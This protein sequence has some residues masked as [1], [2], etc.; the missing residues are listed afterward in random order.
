MLPAG[1]LLFVGGHVL[2]D[3]VTAGNISPYWSILGNAMIGGGTMMM[4]MGMAA[5]P[6]IAAPA[7]A[8]SFF[9]GSIFYGGTSYLSNYA[10]NMTFN[11][12]SSGEASK[13][14]ALSSILPAAIG[15]FKGGLTA[16]A[17]DKNFWWGTKVGNKR[18]QWSFF[19]WD[20]PKH[21]VDF[22]IPY[23][24]DL[25]GKECLAKA[26]Y[27]L[28]QKYGGNRSLNDFKKLLGTTTEGTE[29][30]MDELRDIVTLFEDLGFSNEQISG[31]NLANYE[32]VLQY[33]QQNNAVSFLKRMWRNEYH[34]SNIDKIKFYPDYTKIIPQHGSNF[35]LNDIT[36][37]YMYFLFP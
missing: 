32:T 4:G 6:G 24:G 1:A 37:K 9:G 16:L 36:F 28:E 18:S 15:G 25:D 26:A 13:S 21:V 31:S 30:A 17:N 29:L 19:N 22:D 3:Q 35:R 7:M 20:L 10:F 8:E 5:V 27:E 14:A 11:N 23:S 34:Y 12:M 2:N 33:K